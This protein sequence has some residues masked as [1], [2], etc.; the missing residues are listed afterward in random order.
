MH[1]V[2]NI[3][4]L[5]HLTTL[6]AKPNRRLLSS[7]PE[8][9]SNFEPR[10]LPLQSLTEDE[11]MFQEM[12]RKFAQEEIA[13]LVTEMDNNSKTDPS[14]L[15]SL[16]ENGFMGIEVPEEYDGAGASFLSNVLAIEEFAR[17]DPSMSVCIAIQNTLVNNFFKLYASEDLKQKYLTQLATSKVGSFCLSEGSA[18]SDAF[19]LK[20][21][22]SENSDGSFSI[23]GEKMWITNSAEAEIYLVM[24]NLNPDLGYK[25]ITCFVVDRDTPGFSVSKP[26]NKL[27]I[28]ASSTC[29]LTFDDVQ[30]P[31]ENLL[32]ERGKGYKYAIGTLNEGRIAIAAQMLGLAQGAFDATLP[33]LGERKQ[34]GQSIGKFQGMELQYA[35][36]AS[37]IEAARLMVYNAARKKE[38]GEEF[39]K[40]AS[41]AKWYA[42]EVAAE[43][44]RSCVEWMGGVGFTKEFPQEKFYRDSLIGGIYEGTSN[45]QLQ[46]IAKVLQ[47]EYW[48]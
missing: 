12:C 20:T 15:Q 22:A 40:E 30:V 27:G 34:F 41:M 29:V 1:R 8:L 42:A 48:N 14:L 37:K 35:A 7:V 11:E 39:L 19:A 33:Y 24:A 9:S 13:P 18:G 4:K 46:T 26:E 23:T 16:F 38:N 45:I 10:H 44:S 43:V 21:R 31:K 28:R 5:S 6:K 2:R 47:K 32:G 25:G 36:A 17:V 3:S